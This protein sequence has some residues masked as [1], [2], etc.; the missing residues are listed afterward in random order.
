MA[1]ISDIFNIARS[2]IRATQQGLA[3]TSHNITNINTKGYSRQEV[4]LETAR[5][6]EGTIGSGVRVAAIRQSVDDFLENQLTSV[7][8]DLGSISARNNY[9]VQAD[10]IFTETDNSGLSFSLTEFFN[11][12]RDLATNPES[13]IQRTVLLAKGQSLS[14]QFVTVAQGLN[15]IRLDANGEIARHVDTINGLATKIASLNDVIFK[16]ESSGREALDLQDQRR[17]LINDLAGLVNIEQVPLNDGIGINVGGQLLVA[18]NH[19]NALSTEADPDN[20]PMHDVTFVRS[21]GSEFSIS[22][23]IHGGQIGGLLAQR[24]GDMVEFQDQVDRLAAVLI[25]E[26]NQQHQA[27]YGLDGTTNNNFFSALSPQPP[28][29]YDR[30]T[31]S[32]TGSS[33]T[34]ADPTLATFQEYEVQFS[35]ASAYSVV[36]TETGATVTSG[37]YTSG[38]PL[39]F[40]GLDVVINGTPAAG[41]VFYVNAQKGAAQQFAVALSDTD[42]IAAASTAAGIPGNNT[43]ALNLVAIH[44]NRHVDLGNVTLNDY[45]TITIGD[46]GSAT[47]EST[48]ALH[49]KQL[50]VDQLTALRESVSGVSLDEELTNLL[51]FQRSFEAS[52]RMIT[53]ADELMQTMLAMGR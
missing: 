32:A 53:V 31:G 18:G 49:S 37:A 27:G 29:A 28:L 46:V 12:V 33:V 8:E 6:A 9:L 1:G 17:V 52:A 40:D 19:A 2:G 25:N 43:N 11:A 42:K 38:S 34:I 4:V 16:T 5:P 30:N 36:N 22:H 45:H 24:D 3:T 23:N 51:S 13:T 10:G 47:Q 20:P 44:T 48:Q 14:D 15:Q 50:E 7:K 21:D 39:S 41:D 26:F 35:G